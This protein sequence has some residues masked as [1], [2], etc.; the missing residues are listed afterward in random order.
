MGNRLQ[1]K[2]ALVTG[3][4]SGIGLAIATQFSNEGAKVVIVGRRKDQIDAALL[5][6]GNG[7]SGIVCDVSS[8][9]ALDS[10]YA[11]IKAK[12]GNLDVLVAN[13]GGGQFAPLGHITKEQ[14]ASMFSTNVNGVIFTVQKALPLLSPGA[15]V[16]VIGSTASIQP[17]ATVSVYGAT[18]AA[19]RNLVRNW[20][21]DL[22]GSGIRV[23]VLSPGPVNTQ[24]LRD[25]FGPEHAEEGIATLSARSP[26]GRIGEPEEIASVALFLASEDSSYVNGIELFVDGG[27]SHV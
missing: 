2:I 4:S 17:G 18:K 21:L 14:V 23:N 11:E 25:V 15:S 16:V 3:G 9:E 26:I 12:H 5:R 24:S 10:L 6:I 1:N 19:V 22:K 7:S 8:L 27:A 13:A 20:V